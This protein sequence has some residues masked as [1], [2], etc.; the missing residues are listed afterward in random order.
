MISSAA[1]V[2]S[3]RASTTIPDPVRPAACSRRVGEDDE[4]FFGP[5]SSHGPLAVLSS[6]DQSLRRETVVAGSDQRHPHWQILLGE[7]AAQHGLLRGIRGTL[8]RDVH[9]ISVWELRK[10]VRARTDRSPCSETVKIPKHG[11]DLVVG[12]EAAQLPQ[13]VH[14]DLGRLQADEVHAVV[15]RGG[16]LQHRIYP[17]VVGVVDFPVRRRRV[18]VGLLGR[19]LPQAMARQHGFL[20][21]NPSVPIVLRQGYS[22]PCTPQFAVRAVARHVP[23][24][25]CANDGRKSRLTS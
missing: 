18:H 12:F 1:I 9:A 23:P 4:L 10:T 15:S 5:P 7:R 19:V 25:G 11:E 17:R 8:V 13:F 24:R 22:R 6:R 14:H 2:D 3:A 20:M 21:G 16:R